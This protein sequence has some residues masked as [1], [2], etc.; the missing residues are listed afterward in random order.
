MLRVEHRADILIAGSG[1]AGSALA[2]ALAQSGRAVAVIDPLAESQREDPAFDGRAY[3]LAPASARLLRAIGIWDRVA[4]RAQPILD[5]SVCDG[6]PGA[7]PSPFLLEFSHAEIEEG[8]LGHMIEDRFLRRAFGQ[9]MRETAGVERIAA[10]ATAQEAAGQG[11]ALALD[12][13]ATA[14]GRLLAGCDGRAS[15]TA[16]RA[17]I[18]RTGWEYGQSALIAAVAHALPHHGVAHQF[19]MPAGPLAI[20]PLP[21]NRSSIV[22]SE[23]SAT[24]ARFADLPDA[25]F[26]EALRPRFG[27]FLGEIS[28]CGE[29]S[30]HPL[31]LS[32]ASSFVAERVAL[33]G[34][35]ARGV[36]PL[37]GQGLNAGLR[38][39]AALAQVVRD[40][41]RRGEDFA[42]PHTLARYQRW[43]G[44]DSAGLALAT[45]AANRLFSNDNPL[46][47]AARGLGMAALGSVP[48]LRRALIRE[49]AGLTGETPALMKG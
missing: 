2:L 3:A 11:V 18:A 42:S 7:G 30:V 26:L 20:L 19:F 14:T 45:D 24:A 16:Q 39:A 12:T 44:F 49:A 41:A 46:L 17:G 43:R 29:R 25:G 10:S 34:D 37:A 15:P 31:A 4:E 13:G 23:A 1:L 8:P 47:R 9:A 48:A 40:A 33:V 28:L 6:R 36:H 38:D 22:W 32:Y 35:A 27:D 21:G 5:I